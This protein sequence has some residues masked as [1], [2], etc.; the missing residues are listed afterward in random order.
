[1]KSSQDIRP[2]AAPE[3][4]SRKRRS[5]GAEARERLL[6][7]ALRLFAERGFDKTS[8]RGIAQAAGVNIAAINYYF[9]D[10]AGLYRAVFREPLGT[11]CGHAEHVAGPELSLRDALDRFISHFLEPLKRSDLAHLCTRLHF[12][13]MLEPTGMWQE[14]LAGFRLMHQALVRLLARHLGVSRADDDLH[15]LAF[16]ITGLG[17]QMVVFHDAVGE[18]RPSLLKSGRAVDAWTGRLIE[19]AEA[20]IA[21]EAARRASSSTQKSK[22]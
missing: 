18:I 8:T 4:E 5:D 13:E 14:N 6:H 21:A 20:M 16:A 15:R 2:Q 3:P 7:A 12:R 9:G 17:M 19:Y 1:M 22:A 11:A 10:K